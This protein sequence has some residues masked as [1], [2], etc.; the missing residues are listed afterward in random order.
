MEHSSRAF[1]RDPG[2]GDGSETAKNPGFPYRGHDSLKLFF[3]VG[4]EKMIIETFA[5]FLGFIRGPFR[6]GYQPA[7]ICTF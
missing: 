5:S 3:L 4:L 7:S 2:G 1:Q 6:I